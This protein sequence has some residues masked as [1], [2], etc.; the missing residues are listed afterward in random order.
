MNAQD[1][2]SATEEAFVARDGVVGGMA[3][4]WRV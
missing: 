3:S 2:K 4:G 1:I